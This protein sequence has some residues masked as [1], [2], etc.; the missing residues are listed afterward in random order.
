M[1]PS[2]FCFD[3]DGTLYQGDAALPGAVALVAR[4]RKE[5]IP[6]RFLSNTTSRPRR[7]LAERLRRY[8]F[9]VEDGEILS[10]TV[11]G[12]TWIEAR[13]M[14]RVAAIVPRASL[15]DLPFEHVDASGDQAEVVVVGDLREGWTDERLQAAFS[16]LMGGARL[17]A[18]S[19]DRYWHDGER[20]VMDCGAYV[21]ALEYATG[22][23]A[24]L[25]GKPSANFFSA[26]LSSLPGDIAPADVVM[27]GDD[28]RADVGGAQAAGMQGWLMRTGKFS[29]AA[30]RESEVKPDR[31]LGTLEEVMGRGS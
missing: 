1:T 11:A 5:G 19:R 25:A 28:L 26:A 27:I 24:E 29:E 6:V 22:V 13:G 18:L 30:L 31:V 3:L 8:G 2:A 4:L 7:A 20:L 12:A 15:E 9:S 17:L 16:Q 23:T 14:S 10:A 21:A